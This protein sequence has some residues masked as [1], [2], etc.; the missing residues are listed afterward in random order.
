MLRSL[1]FLGMVLVATSAGAIE[2][3]NIIVIFTDD[4]G[5]N[6]VGCYGSKIPTPHIDKLASE[7]V[8]FTRFYS[9]SAICT[10]SRFGLLTGQNPSRSH[11]ELLG[12]LMFMADEHKDKGIRKHET[13]IAEVL[14]RDAGF[15]TALIGKWHL[16][17]GG[18]SRLPLAHGFDRFI[19]HT[20]GCIDYFTMT[21]GNIPDWHHDKKIVNENG[22]ATDLISDEAIKFLNGQ[23]ANDADQK[24]F[25]LLLAYNAPHFGKAWNPS[26]QVPVNMMQPNTDTMH[27]AAKV[28]FDDKVRR[29]FAAMT[30]SLD[31][32]VGRVM[33][34]LDET[35]LASNTLVIFQTDHGGDPVY[36]GSN[37]PLRAGKATLFEGGV[38][39]PCIARWPG[40]IKPGSVND[41]ILTALDWFPTFCSAAGVE[42]TNEMV[43][44]GK[45]MLPKLT[46]DLPNDAAAASKRTLF[47]ELGAHAELGRSPWSAVLEGDW[48]YVE[49]P[50][51]GEFLFNLAEDENETTNL[52]TANPQMLQSMRAERDRRRKLYRPSN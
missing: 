14:R 3:P 41:Q 22:Y 35:K 7:G 38:R 45:D 9:A 48:K 51:D 17:H 52:A 23:S 34:A 40:K 16:G 21:Y 42:L 37:K 33:K 8:R 19:G 28:G 30:I 2:K 26:Q 18:E 25:F 20:G 29:E 10:P 6:D 31:D 32:G 50:R 13:T 36:G 4:Q 47:W 46:S 1:L 5:W 27:R 49:T 44:D 39:V 12:A 11:D 43:I 24:P 15:H